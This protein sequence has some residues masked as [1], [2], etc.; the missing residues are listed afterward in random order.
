MNLGLIQGR[1][2]GLVLALVLSVSP[3][4]AVT[5]PVTDLG[6]LLEP[7]GITTPLGIS[8][9][10]AVTGVCA[11]EIE[12]PGGYVIPAFRGFFWKDGTISDLGAL[13]GSEFSFG[14][15]VNESE[16]VCGFTLAMLNF[17]SMNHGF[18]WSGGTMTDLGTLPGHKY[19]M[20][21]GM[22]DEGAVVGYSATEAEPNVPH[23]FMWKN[24]TMTALGSLS[25]DP[26]SWAWDINNQ[27]EIVGHS[28]NHAFVYRYGSMVDLG[29]LPGYGASSQAMAINDAGQIAGISADANGVSHSFLYANDVMTDIGQLS[30]RPVTVAAAISEGGLIVGAS[31]DPNGVSNAFLWKQ[32][33]MF[34]LN[35][36]IDPNTGWVLEVATAINKNGWI[37]GTGKKEGKSRGFLIKVY[38]LSTSVNNANYG[39]VQVDPAA[40]FYEP[41]TTVT[42]TAVPNANKSFNEWSGD[43]A[44]GQI[45]ENPIVV[46]MDSS[47]SIQAAFKCGSGVA[48]VLP[49]LAV[50]LVGLTL[51]RRKR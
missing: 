22:N 3:V 29:T 36:L 12:F 20:A 43:I 51:L 17:G 28:N 14:R 24:G 34:N 45:N 13:V 27:D 31:A 5:Y 50:G 35:D 11:F 30:G 1:R 26:G 42:L 41:N 39:S 6:T 18:L 2:F 47:K 25:P 44:E 49:L 7:N 10:G 48:P 37:V 38:T 8:N 33:T 21:F 32:G 4:L 9:T 46:T 23:A 40:D 16:K 15:A 19:S